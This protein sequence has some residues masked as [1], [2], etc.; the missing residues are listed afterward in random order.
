M[1]VFNAPHISR[2]FQPRRG[3]L[4]AEWERRGQV[5]GA[6][7]AQCLRRLPKERLRKKKTAAGPNWWN[8][9]GSARREEIHLRNAQLTEEAPELILYD[10]WQRAD[11]EQ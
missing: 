1:I 2:G 5:D 9:G 3:P 10:I 6:A 4:G 11:D 8:V 7:I